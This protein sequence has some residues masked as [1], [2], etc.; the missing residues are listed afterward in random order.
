MMVNLIW[1]EEDARKSYIE[2]G[3]EEGREEGV[4]IGE[5][6]TSLENVRNL[7]KNFKLTAEAAMN[8]LD[9]SPE[10]QRELEPLI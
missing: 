1:N 6:K 10:M 7:M 3:R 4:A 2:Q 8:A 5:R 9:I